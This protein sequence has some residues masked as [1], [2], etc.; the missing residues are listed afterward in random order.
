MKKVEAPDKKEQFIAGIAAFLSRYRRALA[1]ILG[2]IAVVVVGLF[3]ALEIR[4]ARIDNSLARLESLEADYLS[5]R[6][7]NQE[8]K[9]STIDQ[10]FDQIE[11]IISKYG[12]LYP[13]QRALFLRGQINVVQ[14]Q[15]G[16]AGTAFSDVASQFPES[17]L[18]P[19]ALMQA[20]I[21]FENAEEL[22]SAR[23]TL[24]LLVDD[25][26]GRSSDV[27]RAIFSL[28]RLSEAEDNAVDAAL[29]YNRLVDDY[30]ASSWTNL[31]R[32]RIITLTIQGRIDG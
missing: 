29:F 5:W 10:L 26:S 18:A 12:R 24:S 1:I 7:L 20:A 4:S 6:A 27:A 17:Y 3:V 8:E 31:A 14:N 21:A 25:Y 15:W 11:A 19:V 9:L 28:G 30:P 22:E 13:V 32:D 2:I 16:E 23:T